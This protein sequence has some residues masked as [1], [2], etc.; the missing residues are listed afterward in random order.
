MCSENQTSILEDTTSLSSNV[1]I[2]TKQSK[3]TDLY[4][5]KWTVPENILYARYLKT[6]M[7]QMNNR[8][9]KKCG[10]FVKMANFIGSKTENQ[11]RSHHQKMM[12]TFKSI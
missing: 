11:C 2:K 12:L 1:E 9:K 6:H 4:S 3:N 8:K 10:K 7:S 5:K